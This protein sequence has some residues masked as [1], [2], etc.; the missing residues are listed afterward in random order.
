[1]KIKN[2]SQVEDCYEEPPRAVDEFP[3]DYLTKEQRLRGFFLLHILFAIYFFTFMAV[4]CDKYFIPSVERICQI[5]DI[6]QVRQ[7]AYLIDGV[8]KLCKQSTF[9]ST[10]CTI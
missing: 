4:I 2:S 5:L 6:S 7:F 1:M 8:I 3:S 10:V 9:L